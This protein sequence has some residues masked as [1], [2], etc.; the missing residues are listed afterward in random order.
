[1]PQAT[2]G[3]RLNDELPQTR[4]AFARSLA[5]ELGASPTKGGKTPTA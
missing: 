2:I 4:P 1:M 5:A 3:Q